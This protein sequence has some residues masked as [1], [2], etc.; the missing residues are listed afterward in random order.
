MQFEF[1]DSGGDLLTIQ[2]IKVDDAT[3][4]PGEEK[5][6]QVQGRDVPRAVKFTVSASEVGG[7][8]LS[9]SGTGPYPLD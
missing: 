8:G 7:K 6:F 3:L 2:S 4:P 9:L 5:H 1:Y